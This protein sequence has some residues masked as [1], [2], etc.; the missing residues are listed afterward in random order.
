M[1]KKLDFNSLEIDKLSEV[2]IENDLKYFD[3]NLDEVDNI[4]IP[5]LNKIS[6]KNIKKV[7]K[8]RNE[9]DK[10]VIV[11]VIVLFLLVGSTMSLYN[12]ALV[13]K[14]P[15]VYKVFKEIN[16]SLNIDFVVS[17][18]GF[19]K[20]VPKIEVNE[21]GKLI[22]ID[23][24]NMIKEDEVKAPQNEREALDLVHS[25]AN[26]IVEAEHKW[27]TTEITPKTIDIALKSV[28]FI[29]GDIDRIKL[30]EGLKKWSMGDFSSGVEVHNIVWA[31]L[32][33]SIG[34]AENLDYEMI[35]KIIDKY[36]KDNK[37]KS[38]S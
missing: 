26:N 24:P 9:F 22:V 30:K 14:I 1:I 31:K 12:P 17:L 5:N 11:N 25:M 38:A 27:G 16:E 28:E 21:S 3:M 4:E 29:D 37:K 8:D 35:N 6:K 10:V 33:G 36:F 7:V 34:I 19:N 23:D 15:P 32:D 2:D 13:Y 20:I 18:L